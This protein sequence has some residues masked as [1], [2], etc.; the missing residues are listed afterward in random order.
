MKTSFV[1]SALI[2][3]GL[4]GMA[5]GAGASD[6]IVIKTKLDVERQPKNEISVV[7]DCI[8]NPACLALID[9]AASMAG[10]PPGAVS[11]VLADIP[12]FETEGEETRIRYELPAGYFY[13]KSKIETI[14]VVP[15]TGDRA[16][17]MTATRNSSSGYVGIDVYTWTPVL[18]FGQGRSWVEADFTIIAIREGAAYSNYSD[19]AACVPLLDSSNTKDLMSCRGSRGVNKGMPACGTVTDP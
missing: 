10:A 17:L 4:L 15:A 8:H 12:R 11:V 2:A 7:S 18:P 5:Q 13:C 1:R 16:S 6:V 14:S 3:L 19:K 9:A